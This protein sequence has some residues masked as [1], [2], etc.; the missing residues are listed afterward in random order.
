MKR[1]S[2]RKKK[3]KNSGALSQL[4]AVLILFL[5][6][7]LVFSLFVAGMVIYS[8]YDTTE[9]N[10]IYGINILQN[11]KKI[12]SLKADEANNEYG[13]YVPFNYLSEIAS[14]GLAG[15]G[16]NVTLFLIGSE[17]RIECQKNSSLIIINGNPI[18]IQSPILFEDGEYLIPV[19]MLEKYINGINIEYDNENMICKISSEIEK[20]DIALKLLL[21]EGMKNAYFPESYKYYGDVPETS[22]GALMP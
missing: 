2:V 4:A 19:S 6:V 20:S 15:D 16:D 13:L 8:F 7:Y 11:N 10:E 9:A 22:D 1:K 12:H 5:A 18:R 3:R 21:P 17:N 14:F